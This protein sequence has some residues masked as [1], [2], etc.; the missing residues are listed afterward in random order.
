METY[1]DPEK[2]N[3]D[4]EVVAALAINA[5]VQMTESQRKAS[6]LV[7]GE[8]Y[9]PEDIQQDYDERVELGKGMLAYYF[10]DVAP[11]LDIG[12]KP[13]KVEIEFMLPIP[14]PE[15]GASIIWC[16]C[17]GCWSRYKAWPEAILGDGKYNEQQMFDMWEGLPV[18]YAGRIDMLAEDA[19]GNYWIFDWKTAR[20]VSEQYEFLYLDDQV[21]SYVW[22]LRKLGIDV[23][24]FVYHEQK[25][26]Y[27]K[28]PAENKQRRLGR[29]FSVNKMQD[30]D[31]ESYLAAVKD[32]DTAAYEQGLYDEFLEYLELQGTAFFARH[33]IHKSAAEIQET[34][35][36]IGYEA[37]DMTDQSL[38]IYPSPG[39]FGCNFCAFQE[40]CKE[41]NA[42]G[43]YQYMLD[44]LFERKEHYYLRDRGTTESEGAR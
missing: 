3:W 34:E 10:R 21:A 4:R 29:L 16:K 17:N 7:S 23:R 22:A 39:R 33:Q 1:Y 36:N 24:G 42:Q 20:T 19:N 26:A 2:W 37:L 13:V 8:T 44:T 14:N 43:D 30:T 25:K 40:P 38:R 31:Y 5:F 27:P 12:W 9:L 6:L 35:R 11:V 18:V 41:K 28:P 32:K 15:T